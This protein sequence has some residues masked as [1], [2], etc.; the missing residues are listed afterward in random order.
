M[1]VKSKDTD[2]KISVSDIGVVL[3]TGAVLPKAL[4]PKTRPGLST[5]IGVL[6]ANG[7]SDLDDV[8]LVAGKLY[9]DP[10]WIADT[11]A[12]V[13]DAARALVVESKLATMRDRIASFNDDNSDKI[14]DIASRIAT[15]KAMQSDVDQDI[16]SLKDASCA[17]LGDDLDTMFDLVWIDDPPGFYVGK[18]AKN[19][20]RESR[21][22]DYLSKTPL[23]YSGYGGMYDASLKYDAIL[24]PESEANKDGSGSWSCELTMAGSGKTYTVKTD[25]SA[26][27]AY[28][29]AVISARQDIAEGGHVFTDREGKLVVIDDY[30]VSTPDKFSVPYTVSK[31][32]D[33]NAG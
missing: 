24:A 29:R 30:P 15:I 27:D 22:Y 3:P 17:A 11:L 32:T 33:D 23:K 19:R 18:T 7:V 16:V 20:D 21:V 31:D 26:H 14:D 4:F 9:D 2:N 6:D 25:Q 13:S 8:K 1:P 28:T 10:K 12:T 5:L